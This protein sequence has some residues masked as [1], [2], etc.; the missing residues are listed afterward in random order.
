MKITDRAKIFLP[1]D[2][3]K[4]F[5]EALREQE[6]VKVKKKDLSSDQQEELET[7]FQQ[8]KTNDMVKVVYY[9]KDDESYLSIE[10]VL[11]KIDSENHCIWIVKT[12]ILLGDIYTIERLK[13]YDLPSLQDGNKN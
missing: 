11:S 5:R 8:L 13:D 7:I 4:G 2:A 6:K 1:F 10:G 3:L 12:K 9:S